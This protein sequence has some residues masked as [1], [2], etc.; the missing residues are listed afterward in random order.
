[1]TDGQTELNCRLEK[2]TSENQKTGKITLV[3]LST[4]LLMM[5]AALCIPLP[6]GMKISLFLAA[7]LLAGARILADALKNIFSGELFDENFLMSAAS[8]GAFA[9]GEMPEAVSVMVFYGIGEYLQD[10]A[11][12]K[13]KRNIENLMDL[14]SD[15]ANVKREGV[16]Q[17]IPPENIVPGEIIV[18]K[19]GERV[20]LDG[21]VENGTAFLDSRAL[22]GESIPE[23]VFPG[24]D[25]LSGVICMDGSLEIR[26]QKPFS[27]STVSR[28]L[29][30]VRNAAG[31]KAST[32]KFIT[33]FARI[34]TPL[35][36]GAALLVAIV[37]PLGGFGTF[38]EWIYKALTFLFISCPCAWFSPF[39]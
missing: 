39:L 14:R 33:K 36:V 28:I 8:I 10:S 2:S 19:P 24:N 37:P 34:Y 32:E 11:V 20:P 9:I 17:C 4:A 31:R 25:I 6:E 35:V 13:S 12:A 1:M 23:K 5:I 38:P 21:R 3:L 7:Y 26:V 16:I 15:Y 29:E 22:T 27:E 30:L 18:V